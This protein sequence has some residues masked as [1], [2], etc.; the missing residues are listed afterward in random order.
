MADAL[1]G[2]VLDQLNQRRPSQ[3]RVALKVGEHFQL[4]PSDD[5]IYASLS[6]DVI[7]VVAGRL[8]GTSNFRS[9]DELQ[10]KLDPEVF[11]AGASFASRQHQ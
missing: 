5:I 11:L 8:T 10:S 6:D 1:L 9:L 4:V 7:T 2:R 3:D